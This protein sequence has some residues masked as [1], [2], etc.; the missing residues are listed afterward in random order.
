MKRDE[1]GNEIQ[2]SQETL[3]KWLKGM[4]DTAKRINLIVAGELQYQDLNIIKSCIEHL[5]QM[6]QKDFIVS[7]ESDKS[8]YEQAI[9]DGKNYLASLNQ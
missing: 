3:A 7:H 4:D 6:L 9:S 5:E 8:F 2:M 1:L